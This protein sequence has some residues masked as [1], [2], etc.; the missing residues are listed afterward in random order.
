[1]SP[2]ASV[3]A[4]R[5]RSSCAI[6]AVK[7]ASAR[8]RSASAARWRASSLTQLVASAATKNAPS[9]TQLRLSAIVNRPTGG[10]WKKLN[11]AALSN[12]VAT[13][14][15][16]PQNADT[17]TTPNMYTTP[18]E[19]TVVSCLRGYTIPVQPATSATAT[20]TPTIAGGRRPLARVAFRRAIMGASVYA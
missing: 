8:R 20:I 9:A 2:S 15:H 4:A 6:S 13:P 17:T 12:D 18:R 7:S 1:M 10:R 11:A 3:T 5:G 14:S 19:E 16:T